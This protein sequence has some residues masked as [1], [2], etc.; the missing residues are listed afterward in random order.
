MKKKNEHKEG[1]REEKKRERGREG[2]TLWWRK[3]CRS[4]PLRGVA[5]LDV[6]AGVRG[7]S[8]TTRRIGRERERTERRTEI[9]EGGGSKCL[10]ESIPVS[11][12]CRWCV[13]VSLSGVPS[14]E[15]Q[16]AHSRVGVQCMGRR[17]RGREEGVWIDLAAA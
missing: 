10:R 2:E 6:V 1:K 17:A 9:W 5:D 13:V 11:S 4:R 14:E 16:E 3:S 8:L 15:E 12:S 7:V